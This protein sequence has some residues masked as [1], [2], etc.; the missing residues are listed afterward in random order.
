MYIGKE[1]CLLFYA[2]FLRAQKTWYMDTQLTQPDGFYDL[3]VGPL[4]DNLPT[5]LRPGKAAVVLG[6]SVKTIYDWHYRRRLRNVPPAL[7]L[8]VNRFLYLRTDILKT[9]IASQNPSRM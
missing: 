5:L 4:F 1:G 2:R 8:K 3:S 9:W 6:V 7:F